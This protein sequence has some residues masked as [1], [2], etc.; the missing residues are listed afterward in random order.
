MKAFTVEN[1]FHKLRAFGVTLL[2]LFDKN[3]WLLILPAFVVL[4]YIDA[5]MAKTMVQWLGFALIL[6]GV[7]IF[8]S[9]IVFPQINLTE[10]VAAAKDGNAAAGAVAG[11]M[12]LFF[13]FLMV[14]LAIWA[15][16]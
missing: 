6:A 12:I 14:A 13:G 9:R 4:Y 10:L 7:S 3:A 2:S 16:P 11:A 1:F 5:A 8:I 15:K